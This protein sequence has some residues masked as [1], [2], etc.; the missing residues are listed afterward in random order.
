[1]IVVYS[2]FC[3]K[4]FLFIPYCTGN[5]EHFYCAL[6]L[7]FFMELVKYNFLL[8]FVL[9]LYIKICLNGPQNI[10]ELWLSNNIN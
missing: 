6:I 9:F 2:Y 5:G 3:K 4:Y 8:I 10:F 1:M 7:F